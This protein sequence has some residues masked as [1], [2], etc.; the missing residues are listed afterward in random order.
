VR[1]AAADPGVKASSSP[2]R[3]KTFIAGADITEFGKPPVPPSLPEVIDA[4]DA[5]AKPIVAAI[6]GAALGGG[7]EVA[8]GC[9]ARVAAPAAKLG[10]PEV[11]LGLLPGAGGTQRLPRL[12]GAAQALKLMADGNP[13]S[14]ADALAL[15]L[16]DEVAEGDVIAAATAR[17]RALA[18]AGGTPRRS[19]DLTDRIAAPRRAGGVRAGRRRPAE[20]RQATTRAWPPASK[21]CAPS[22][23]RASRRGR[24]S[25]GATSGACWRTR[26]PRRSGTSSSPSA[27]AP[28]SPACRRA[29]PRGRWRARP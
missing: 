16:V 3:A 4:F 9:H 26:G 29:P 28:A 18:A 20:A 13:V 19:R 2:P 25:N 22:S 14:A 10:L 5:V 8:L 7:L 27:R 11:K 17:A 15:G 6:G 24:R 1:R 12:I 21:P 23:R